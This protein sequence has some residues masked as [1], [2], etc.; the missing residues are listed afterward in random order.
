MNNEYDD[1][2]YKKDKYDKN[3]KY[4]RS[5]KHDRKNNKREQEIKKIPDE[6]SVE[7]W[8][9]LRAKLGLNLIPDKL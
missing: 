4:D 7:Y 1:R 9:S 3:H 2:D 8:N 5:N 6:N